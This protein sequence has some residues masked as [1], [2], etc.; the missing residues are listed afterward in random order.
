MGTARCPRRRCKTPSRLCREIRWY[1]GR[2]IH[3]QTCCNPVKSSAPLR[4]P[5]QAWL[6][7][8]HSQQMFSCC[9]Q[10]QRSWPGQCFPALKVKYWFCFYCLTWLFL[11]H[12]KS[13]GSL[14]LRSQRRDYSVLWFYDWG[15]LSSHGGALG[16]AVV[17]SGS[18]GLSSLPFL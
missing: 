11:L 2:I 16:L 7:P 8:Y 13:M 14:H 12:L 9:K 18:A 15:A 3:E 5:R 17:T 10:L 1:K 6:Y 4:S